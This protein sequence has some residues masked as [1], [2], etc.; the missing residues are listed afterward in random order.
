MSKGC[1]ITTF[2][3]TQGL[4]DMFREKPFSVSVSNRIPRVP[5]PTTLR[6]PNVPKDPAS[7]S[8]L[9][10]LVLRMVKKSFFGGVL[11]WHK[12]GP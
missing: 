11:R 8:F 12:V 3:E 2:H 6:R 1:T 7:E 4:F 9:S 10:V 5:K